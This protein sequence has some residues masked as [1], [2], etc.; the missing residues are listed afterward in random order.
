[1]LG[2]RAGK[3]DGRSGEEVREGVGRRCGEDGEALSAVF[4]TSVVSCFFNVS[5]QLSVDLSTSRPLTCTNPK[6][7]N[8]SNYLLASLAEGEAAALHNWK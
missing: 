5:C 8:L 6:I 2:G 7:R 1:M 3:K 4:S